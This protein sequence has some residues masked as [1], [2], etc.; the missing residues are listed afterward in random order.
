MGPQRFGLHQTWCL[1]SKKGDTYDAA[2]VQMGTAAA[3]MESD[4]EAAG[5]KKYSVIDDNDEWH[6]CLMCL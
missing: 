5:E 6:V 3:D 2:D 1:H 4:T